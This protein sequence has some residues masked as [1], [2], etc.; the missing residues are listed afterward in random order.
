LERSSGGRSDVM[1][2]CQS[3]QVQIFTEQPS[4]CKHLGI[5]HK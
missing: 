2:R 5:V 1:Y 4:R 3:G